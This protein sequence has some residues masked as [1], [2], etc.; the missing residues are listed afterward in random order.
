[1]GEPWTSYPERTPPDEQYIAGG[2]THGYEIYVWECLR[3][4]RVVVYDYKAEWSCESPKRQTAPCGT[5]TPI[6]VLTA[7]DPRRPMWE[8]RLW[9]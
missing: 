8:H 5:K 6:E 4:Q 9:R 7:S 3:G 1:M 2:V